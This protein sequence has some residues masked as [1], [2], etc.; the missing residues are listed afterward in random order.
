MGVDDNPSVPEKHHS[1]FD[2]VLHRVGDSS[3]QRLVVEAAGPLGA[4]IEAFSRCVDDDIEVVDVHNL[5]SVH[6]ETSAITTTIASTRGERFRVRVTAKRSRSYK[7]TG[8]DSHS[9]K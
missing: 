6:G 5:A 2:V 9:L 1:R 7:A 8:P 3:R 4:A